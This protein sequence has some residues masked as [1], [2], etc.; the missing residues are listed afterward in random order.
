[1]ETTLLAL[2]CSRP[3]WALWRLLVAG[4]PMP[5]CV[6]ASGLAAPAHTLC[7]SAALVQPGW[8]PRQSLAVFKQIKA[9]QGLGIRWGP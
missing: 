2:G 1:M 3:S 9:H 6:L 5:E 7:L 8:C 4:W